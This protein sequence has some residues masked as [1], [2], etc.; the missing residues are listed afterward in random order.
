MR[1]ADVQLGT[2]D[3][4]I[5]AITLGGSIGL[6]L[7]ASK[8]GGS[9]LAAYFVADRKL[10]W[11]IAGTSIVA[12]SFAA[13]TPLAIARIVRTQGLL[14]NWY[15]W[16]GAIGFVVCMF[17]FAPLWRRA[18]LL[19]DAE[20]IELRYGGRS[21]SALRGF[22]A[23]YR[24]LLANGITMGWVILGMQ[25][26]VGEAFGWPKL[27]T[28]LGLV[29]LSL[30]YTA[31][32]GLWGVVLTDV[33]QF[34]LAMIGSIALMI[35]VYAEFGGPAE[36]AAAVVEAAAQ[37]PASANIADAATLLD[38]V[39]DPSAGAVVVATFGF[40]FGVQW[41]GGMEGG[42]FL[43]Q[44][45]FA[46]RDERHAVLALLWFVV[47]HFALRAWPWVVVGLG[48]IVLL[49]ELADPETAYPKLMMQLLPS[50]LLGLM[51]ASLLAA[52]MSTI[53]THLHWGSSYL[54]NDL[55]LRFVRP[56][57]SEKEAVRAGQGGVLAMALLAGAMATS[58]DSV[59]G[60]WLYLAE[61][62]AGAA[63]VGAMRWY[64]WRLNARAE[65]TALAVS[66][67]LS[68]ALR[69]ADVCAALGLPDL[70][71]GDL[72]PLRFTVVLVVGTG[73]AVAVALATAP[74]EARHLAA[75]YRRVRPSGWWGPVA[76]ACP[77]TVAQPLTEQPW[78]AITLGVT[79]VFASMF[80]IGALALGMW[81]K[82]G[83]LSVVA[84]AAGA[85]LLQHLP[86]TDASSMRKPAPSG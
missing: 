41:L 81:L 2:L 32:S 42:G 35:A 11:W 71:L 13:D 4:V 49:P 85:G 68:N 43:V 58:M 77:E 61:I 82:A 62:G 67:L 10:P 26:I 18:E 24:G 22:L 34:G 36:L 28:T 66:L 86:K 30:A 44:R 52:F 74:T 56:G 45:L 7:A 53:S 63:L 3:L 60:A 50:G 54:V 20:V 9:G 59:F 19:T 17:L 72:Y 40:Y 29:A 14:G 25:K 37:A 6:G 69:S 5:I 21:A 27:Q 23:L 78:L 48:S 39:P 70:S 31:A 75:F 79:A 51:V 73:A 84:L 1:G 38:F 57:C 64:W 46:T 55:Y 8:R 47:A 16:S 12:T 65:I 33:L 15:W 76:T 80:G 83:V